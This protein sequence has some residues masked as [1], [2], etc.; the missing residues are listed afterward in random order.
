MN[1][2]AKAVLIFLLLIGTLPG[3][4][5]PGFNASGKEIYEANCVAC[6]GADGTRGRW[7][8][9]NLQKSLLND[10]QLLAVIAEGKRIM[11]AWK[12]RLPADQL[13]L[14]RDYVLLL[15]KP[16]IKPAR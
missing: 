12:K 16:M 5:S 14:V 4:T 7:G 8:A 10:E 15:R 1:K 2:I 9:K 11:P 3:I 6:H 13:L